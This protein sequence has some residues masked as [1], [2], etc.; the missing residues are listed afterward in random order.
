[1]SQAQVQIPS[2][3]IS[4]IPHLRVPTLKFNIQTLTA[5]HDNNNNELG[6]YLQSFIKA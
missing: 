4:S 6:L 3:D 1:L 2:E 5:L